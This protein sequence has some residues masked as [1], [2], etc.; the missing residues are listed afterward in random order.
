MRVYLTNPFSYTLETIFAAAEN[1]YPIREVKIRTNPATRPSRLFTGFGPVHRRSASIIVQ[2]YSMHNP[3]RAFGWL[4][5]AVLAAGCRLGLRFLY[6]LPA[7]SELQ[8]PHPV[9][10]PGVDLHRRRRADPNLRHARLA[11]AREPAAAAGHPH[12]RAAARAARGREGQRRELTAKPPQSAKEDAKQKNRTFF[13]WRLPWRSAAAW[14]VKLSVPRSPSPRR[15]RLR[16]RRSAR[17]S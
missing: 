4:V 13:L 7:Q 14:R 2:G 1:R 16:C 17:R 5:A 6:L 8:R 10:D 9:A 12:A 11:G 15:P 3:L